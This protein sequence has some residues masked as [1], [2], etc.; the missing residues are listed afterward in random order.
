MLC[1]LVE[2]TKAFTSALSGSL[3]AAVEAELFQFHSEC[4]HWSPQCSFLPSAFFKEL[5][6]SLQ[7][8]T[9][10]P[11]AFSGLCSLEPKEPETSKSSLEGVRI[12]I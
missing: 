4:G 8:V 5:S 12:E 7:T 10:F 3:P 2:A 6:P 1:S 11:L 9:L